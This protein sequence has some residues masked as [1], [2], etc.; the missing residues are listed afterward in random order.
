ML[1]GVAA[2]EGWALVI[3]HKGDHLVAMDE[4]ARGQW[5]EARLMTLMAKRKRWR[6]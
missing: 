2:T 5:P 4:V 6:D 1:R 3:D